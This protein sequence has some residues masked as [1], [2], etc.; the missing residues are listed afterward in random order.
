MDR[1]IQSKSAK[2]STTAGSRWFGHQYE[3]TSSEGPG[4]SKFSTVAPLTTAG[5]SP[6][7]VTG[8]TR[9][10]HRRLPT[11]QQA[12]MDTDVET[13]FP[14]RNRKAE[15]SQTSDVTGQYENIID[16]ITTLPKILKATNTNH[17]LLHS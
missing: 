15:Y 17:K 10:T 5:Y 7:M 3:S 8:A 11:H 16:A 12:G 14:S 9:T 13:V 4:A 6:D 2:E 1:L